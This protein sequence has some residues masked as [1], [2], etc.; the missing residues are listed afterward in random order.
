V[1]KPRNLP[2]LSQLGIDETD[3]KVLLELQAQART[4]RNELAE[5][6]G[7]SIP[8]VSE[9]LR[10]LEVERKIINGF[11]TKLAPKSL[12]LDVS[13]FIFVTVE[14]STL[15]QAFL[16]HATQHPEILEVHAITG[17]GSHLLKIRT[18]NTSTLEQLLSEIQS[19][20]GVKQTR[21]NLVLSTPKETTALPIAEL[22]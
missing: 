9:R 18:W 8:A 12:G 10:K 15:Y 3:L 2:P 4:K 5:L 16:E 14:S 6:T 7:L 19:W 21:T 20:K 1:K 11:F 22:K 17:D 13:A